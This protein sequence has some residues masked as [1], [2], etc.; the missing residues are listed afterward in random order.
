MS[1]EEKGGKRSRN[2]SS[3]TLYKE[4]AKFVKAH[5]LTSA[6]TIGEVLAELKDS[7]VAE[8]VGDQGLLD[9]E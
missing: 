1:D 6:A 8:Q 7:I 4:L 5:D 9:L 3:T 2:W